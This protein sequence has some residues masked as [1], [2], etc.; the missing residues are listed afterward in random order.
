V[1]S[2]VLVVVLV[3]VVVVLV[4]VV[5]VLV[6]PADRPGGACGACPLRRV[7]KPDRPAG[8]PDSALGVPP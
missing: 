5:V 8:N 6:V 3:L 2:V 7:A 4:L 1:R